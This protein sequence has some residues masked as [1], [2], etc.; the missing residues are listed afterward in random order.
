MFPYYYY[1]FP[2]LQQLFVC[3]C[4]CVDAKLFARPTYRSDKLPPATTR[5][6]A[7]L[8]ELPNRPTD[9]MPVV[10]PQPLQHIGVQI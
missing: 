4:I 7:L 10:R 9:G 2:Q 8:L 3:V 1:Y 6:V 5:P